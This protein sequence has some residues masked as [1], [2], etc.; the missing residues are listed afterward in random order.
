MDTK[1]Q[2][3][4]DFYT[5]FTKKTTELRSGISALEPS[6]TNL[7]ATMD[8]L[9]A[10][11][12]N[13][14]LSIS[15]SSVFLPLY[16]QRKHMQTIR[17]LSDELNAA[18]AR[19]MPKGKFSFKRK[20]KEPASAP[21]S[22]KPDVKKEIIA[23]HQPS[24][25]TD[26]T[27]LI[28]QLASQLYQ[29]SAEPS[30]E[31][32]PTDALIKNCSNAIVYLDTLDSL[33][34]AHIVDSSNCIIIFGYAISGSLFVERCRSVKIVVACQQL[35]VHT[36]QKLDFFL[37]VISNPIIEDCAE[38]GIAAIQKSGLNVV[39]IKDTENRYDKVEDFYW[40]KA[41]QSPNWRLLQDEDYFDFTSVTDSKISTEQKLKLIR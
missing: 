41:T 5:L 3:S 14:E 8:E 25:N 19:V 32:L 11:I 24:A 12:R 22:E 30:P 9:R 17:E 23:Q 21:V 10:E 7:T 18:Q 2:A 33:S 38:I 20:A 31:K 39:G 4:A 37:H 36:S 1:Q 15:T 6:H 13:M 40:L 26:D 29:A 28:T 27:L 35:R 34:T 16:D